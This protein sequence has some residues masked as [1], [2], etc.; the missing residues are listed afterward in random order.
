MKYLPKNCAAYASISRAIT[1][2]AHGD[3][4]AIAIVNP[5]KQE[6]SLLTCIFVAICKLGEEI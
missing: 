3:Q 2:A 1:Q 6:L 5:L 4:T